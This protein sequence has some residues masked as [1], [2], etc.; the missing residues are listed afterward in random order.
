MT[1]NETTTFPTNQPVLLGNFTCARITV[2]RGGVWKD[3]KSISP[4]EITIS[5]IPSQTET[6]TGPDP[7]TNTIEIQHSS[8]RA[9]HQGWK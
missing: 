2:E 7:G 6:G 1:Q 4:V 8:R 3:L 5:E 9:Y